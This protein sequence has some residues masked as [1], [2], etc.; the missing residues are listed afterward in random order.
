LQVRD[1]RK[2][3][4]DSATILDEIFS[5][6]KRYNIQ[7]FFLETENIARAIGPQS[8]ERMRKESA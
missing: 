6:V 8:Y 7:D 2:G 5:L 3:R 4:W 1:R